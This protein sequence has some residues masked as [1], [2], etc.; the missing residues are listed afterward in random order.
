MPRVTRER[1]P[2]P[3]SQPQYEP[4]VGAG[5]CPFIR[6]NRAEFLSPIRVIGGVRGRDYG[7]SPVAGVAA[8]RVLPRPLTC[9]IADDH[10]AIVASVSHL[11]EETGRFEVVGRAS[12]GVEALA[13][14][15][16]LEPDLALVDV[17]MPYLDGVELLRLVGEEAQGPRVVV[18][19]GERD[20]GRAREA[21][22]AGASAFVLKGVALTELMRAVE[23]VAEGGTYIDAEIASALGGPKSERP[24]ELTPREREVL[25]LLADGLRG[26]EIAERLSISSLTVRTH[27]KHAMDKLKATTRTEAVAIA[28]RRSLLP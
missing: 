14:I 17:N 4:S 23:I 8:Q 2:Q 19:S 18:Y 13:L 1:D 10:P 21:I 20:P 9:V 27:V 15:R 25:R 5:V 26:D 6:G 24:P 12:D 11:L 16:Q 28:M 7:E 3:S 22:A